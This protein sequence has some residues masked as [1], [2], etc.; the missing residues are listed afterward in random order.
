M[1]RECSIHGERRNSCGVLVRKPE[2]KRQLR[3]LSRRLEVDAKRELIHFG[4][5]EFDSSGSEY[6]TMA[7]CCERGNEQWLLHVM[8]LH[9]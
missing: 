1:G 6:G 5:G 9:T 7:G 2:G 3:R 8:Y 4:A